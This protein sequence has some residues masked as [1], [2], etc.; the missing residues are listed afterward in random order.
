[1]NA[2]VKRGDRRRGQ[3]AG[4]CGTLLCLTKMRLSWSLFQGHRAERSR[5]IRFTGGALKVHGNAGDLPCCPCRFPARR[6][7]GLAPTRG[8]GAQWRDPG[9]NL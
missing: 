8:R 5:S 6:L 7:P 3:A 2:P 9:E 4:R 1:M